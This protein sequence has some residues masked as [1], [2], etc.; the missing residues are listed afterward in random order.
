MRAKREAALAMQKGKLLLA[1]AQQ[2]NVAALQ[3]QI[4]AGT[5]P[6]FGNPVGQT[7]LHVAVL[8]GN[9]DAAQVSNRVNVPKFPTPALPTHSFR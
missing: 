1:A 7:A 5:D 8:W 3:E 6:C 9:V 4:D 2:N